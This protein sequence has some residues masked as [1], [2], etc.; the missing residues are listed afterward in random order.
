MH[1]HVQA[2]A[3]HRC[4]ISTSTVFL[5]HRREET[6]LQVFGCGSSCGFGLVGTSGS[7]QSSSL[8][9]SN[10]LLQYQKLGNLFRTLLVRIIHNFC[11]FLRWPTSP[12]WLKRKSRNVHVDWKICKWSSQIICLSERCLK[13][14]GVFNCTRV[15][16]ILDHFSLSLSFPLSSTIVVVIFVTFVFVHVHI[17]TIINID[18][19]SLS[20]ASASGLLV[21]CKRNV[22]NFLENIP[23]HCRCCNMDP[24]VRRIECHCIIKN[25]FDILSEGAI[26]HTRDW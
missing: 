26:Q 15:V 12:L 8:R 11:L 9:C 16:L 14:N 10:L 1:F 20:R 4:H 3:R 18:T 13:T 22:G 21:C 17:R 25:Q 24:V 2:G 5:L 6:H 23:F 7:S 19:S